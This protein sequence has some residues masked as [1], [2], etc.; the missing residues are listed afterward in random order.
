M[1]TTFDRVTLL[2]L[3]SRGR[4]VAVFRDN[5]PDYDVSCAHWRSRVASPPSSDSDFTAEYHRGRMT[6]LAVPAFRS[7]R[8][9]ARPPSLD[10]GLFSA[11]KTTVELTRDI[12]P[13]M[14]SILHTV[15]VALESG[16]FPMASDLFLAAEA[17]IDLLLLLFRDAR[18]GVLRIEVQLYGGLSVSI[19]HFF[20]VR[21]RVRENVVRRC[22]ADGTLE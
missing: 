3:K 21:V 2:I 18:L 17:A 4:N 20:R 22:S 5:C 1:P 12:W 10:P 14:S 8:V 7:R 11:D 13:T 15:T 16:A 9:R 19:L 6:Q